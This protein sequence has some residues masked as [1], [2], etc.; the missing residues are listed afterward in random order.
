MF[1][2]KVANK[3]KT[4]I[5]QNQD[6]GKGQTMNKKCNNLVD[7]STCKRCCNKVIVK[8]CAHLCKRVKFTI[9]SILLD[10]K[11]HERRK[12]LWHELSRFIYLFIYF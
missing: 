8:A 2:K 9:T 3:K 5:G 6:S 12:K 4:R 10:T 1:I 11:A 7:C